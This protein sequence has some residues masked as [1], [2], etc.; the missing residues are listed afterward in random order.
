MK[1]FT[2][3]AFLSTKHGKENKPTPQITIYR[4]TDL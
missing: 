3:L 1:F 2:S 4:R